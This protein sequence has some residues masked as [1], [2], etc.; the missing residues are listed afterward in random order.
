MASTGTVTMNDT[1]GHNATDIMN[2]A[3]KLS[4]N[5]IYR[6]LLPCWF[7]CSRVA[8]RRAIRHETDMDDERFGH[9]GRHSSSGR[10]REPQKR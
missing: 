1:S 6:L 4:K 5:P 10:R 8:G 7:H 2:G 3:E 9:D